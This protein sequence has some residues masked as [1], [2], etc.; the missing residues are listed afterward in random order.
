MSDWLYPLSAKA[1]L[2]F[3]DD[4]GASVPVSLESYRDHILTGKIRD[5]SWYLSTNYRNVKPGDRMWIYFGE[6]DVGVVGV[7]TI[8]GVRP[9][10]HH[11][12]TADIR[13][14]KVRSRRLYEHPYAARRVRQHVWPRAAVA[15]LDAHPSLVSDLESWVESAAQESDI[16]LKELSLKPRR[17]TTKKATRR[18]PM[19]LRHD[20]VLVPIDLELRRLGFDVGV[21]ASGSP[22]ADLVALTADTCV[23]V[24]AKTTN[25]PAG[26]EA[27]RTA[28]GQ[29]HDYSWQ[30]A[31]DH[32]SDAREHVYWVAFERKPHADV[33]EFLEDYEVLV[34]W[35]APSG[36][37]FARWSAKTWRG[38]F[39]AKS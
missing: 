7:A 1:G 28:F 18:K 33:I 4:R 30:I 22:R 2:R 39:G 6:K 31:R 5:D 37:E 11:T 25:Q 34:S 10:G 23:I 27:A 12:W 16:R 13:L 20:A 8:L 14:D 35:T 26:R 3:V 36:F 29:L 17:L 19:D 21:P 24:E 32:P 38:W 15:G 9:D